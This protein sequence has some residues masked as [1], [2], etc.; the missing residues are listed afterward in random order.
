MKTIENG[1]HCCFPEDSAYVTRRFAEL[2]AICREIIMKLP[3]EERDTMLEYREL[4]RSQEDRNI[5]C[6][7]YS[8]IRIGERGQGK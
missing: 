8:G 5:R 2:E 3:A 7:F 1:E 4:L 6:A